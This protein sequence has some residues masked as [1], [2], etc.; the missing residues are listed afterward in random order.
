MSDKPIRL[1]NVRLSYPHI[2]KNEGSARWGD[3]NCDPIADLS[4]LDKYALDATQRLIDN[5]TGTPDYIVITAGMDFAKLELLVLA[6]MVAHGQVYIDLD[7]SSGM[8]EGRRFYPM[9]EPDLDPPAEPK[10]QNGR[11]AAYLKHD[12]SKRHGRR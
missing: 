2:T 12:R 5:T 8:I 11:S 3:H 1:E 10:K 4:R 6:S 9:L 7:T